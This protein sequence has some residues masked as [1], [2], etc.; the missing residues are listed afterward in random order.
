MKKLNI[1]FAAMLLLGVIVVP[2]LAFVA[3]QFQVNR[4]A[5]NLLGRA[6]TLRDE[7]DFREA[8]RLQER[9]LAYRPQDTDQLSKVAL[10]YLELIEKD[11][12]IDR[13]D[14]SR[15]YGRCEEALRQVPDHHELRK[16]TADFMMEV[17][18]FGDAIEH[19]QLMRDTM[20]DDFDSDSVVKLARCMALNGDPNTARREV[21]KLLG[22]D[23]LTSSFDDEKAKA[24]DNV[25]AYL[26]LAALFRDDFEVELAEQVIDH[27]VEVNLGNYE[28]FLQRAKS[29][30]RY[31][32]ADDRVEKAKADI[33]QALELNPDDEQVILTAAKIAIAD[34]DLETAETYLDR[35]V[36]QYPESVAVFTARSDLARVQK[37]PKEAMDW[38]VKGLEVNSES[39][40]L[41][42]KKCELELSESNVEAAGESLVLLRGLGT[43]TDWV[44]YLEVRLLMIEEKWRKASRKLEQTMTSLLAKNPQLTSQV[45]MSL[46]QC[47]ENLE[48]WDLAISAAKTVPEESPLRL[49]AVLIQARSF[50]AKGQVDQAIGNYRIIYE[51]QLEVAEEVSSGISL[52][53]FSLLVA[54]QA[55]LPQ[56]EQDWSECKSVLK[57]IAADENVEKPRKWVAYAE[58]LSAQ[59][60]DEEALALVR[61]HLK[62]SPDYQTLKIFER[63]LAEKLGETVEELDEKLDSPRQRLLL[64]TRVIRLGGDGVRETLI[65]QEEGIDS[66]T[67]E[68]QI[69]LKYGLVSLH[70]GLNLPGGHVRRLLLEIA[71]ADPEDM[72]C[73]TQLFTLGLIVGNEERMGA[74]LR[75]IEELEGTE[76]NEWRLAQAQWLTWSFS[77][78]GEDEEVLQEARNLMRDIQ[79]KRPNWPDLLRLQAQ[80]SILL[81]DRDSA[82]DYMKRIL[83]SG[84]DDPKIIETLAELYLETNRPDAAREMISRLPKASRSTLADKRL[85][86]LKTER[87]SIAEIEKV[88]PS[89]SE[90][91]ADLLW[92]GTALGRHNH[93]QAATTPFR[94][95]TELNPRAPEGWIA[96]VENLFKVGQY[97]AAEDAMR[98][99]QINLPETFVHMTLA[100]CHELAANLDRPRA[101]KQTLHIARA[102]QFYL[103]ALENAPEDRSL[104]QKCAAFYVSVKRRTSA[105]Q[106][107]DRLLEGVDPYDP[108]ADHFTTWARRSK[109]GVLAA[110]GSFQDY[111]E[112]VD[113]IRKNVPKG[114]RLTPDDLKILAQITLTRT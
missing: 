43:R 68:S 30:L 73:R 82:E 7:G 104:L 65:A 9:Y 26:V 60:K 92:K 79:E 55:A 20:G 94:R 41:M 10:N 13:L 67:V 21:E 78:K 1:K 29:I 23:P 24:T 105:L 88:V 25:T 89:D 56:E 34:E 83:D 50:R 33:Q 44:N 77:N 46:A 59:K 95:V 42:L 53:L 27:A 114:A 93:L 98:N 74:A 36:Q 72:K 80:V 40:I 47:Y 107:I 110:T 35:G 111:L 69:Q 61:K 76:S 16:K 87:V 54:R 51:S 58:L 38:L 19:L 57:R 85:I 113:E 28:A 75:M 86:D 8:I 14:I 2:A 5:S 91:A 4:N 112:A 22:F 100:R 66:W 106:Q 71:E 102:E 3:W 99:A 84:H 45:Y 103:Q 31:S 6:N 81:E 109:A 49:A 17:R 32:T 70:R 101:R 96:L 48:T 18:R 63:Q 97:Q 11:K 12:E 62:E 108:N 64:A 39:P 52:S 37:N 90:S 15:A